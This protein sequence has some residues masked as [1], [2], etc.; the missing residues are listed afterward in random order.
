MPHTHSSRQ[1]KT[2]LLFSLQDT[3]DPLRKPFSFSCL[4]FKTVVI[5]WNRFYL[6]PH[7]KSSTIQPIGVFFSTIYPFGSTPKRFLL[8]LTKPSQPIQTLDS[9]HLFITAQIACFTRKQFHRRR[10]ILSYSI[11]HTNVHSLISLS[12]I[13]GVS[14]STSNCSY[15]WP[16]LIHFWQLTQ[17]KVSLPPLTASHGLYSS[18]Q[19]NIISK[20]IGYRSR[21]QGSPLEPFLASFTALLSRPT[22]TTFF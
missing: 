2:K 5:T 9:L 6:L 3:R 1:S 19:W 21:R 14:I 10:Q 18:N 7:T 16:Q 22:I 11:T 8:Q 13:L 12:L 20:C 17:L 4:S 15:F